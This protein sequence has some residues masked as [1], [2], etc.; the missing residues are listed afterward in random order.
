ME[1]TLQTEMPHTL[2]TE[3]P[4]VEDNGNFCEEDIVK[5]VQLQKM[6]RGLRQR[7]Q[8]RIKK[9]END[10]NSKYFKPEEAK[11]TLGQQ[12]YKD[13]APIET[14]THHYKTGA[15]YKGQWKGGLRHGIGEMKWNNDTSYVGDW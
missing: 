12:I 15:V 9:I 13:N 2:Q 6:V 10:L 1:H 8:Y 5:I 3:A 11:E 4:V 14:R 7:R